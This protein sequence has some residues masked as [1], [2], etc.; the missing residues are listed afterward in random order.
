M[1]QWLYMHTATSM[2]CGKPKYKQIWKSRKHCFLLF[3][4]SKFSQQNAYEYFEP[5]R[6]RIFEHILFA[7]VC[8]F[9]GVSTDTG[10][11]NAQRQGNVAV[12][13][14]LAI[15]GLLCFYKFYNALFWRSEVKVTQF[16]PTLCEP[17]DYTGMGSLSLPHGIFPSQRSNPGL[18]HFR[19]ILY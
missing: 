19:Q 13:L 7:G 18:P 5:G 16:Y 11:G 12:S 8:A 17:M 1:K 15:R 3:L 4:C 9:A 10:G 2:V 14:F 6:Q